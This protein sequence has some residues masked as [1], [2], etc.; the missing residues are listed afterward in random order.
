MYGYFRQRT[1]FSKSNI[2]YIWNMW[3]NW[4]PQW[5]SSVCV[6]VYVQNA[7]MFFMKWNDCTTVKWISSERMK[8]LTELYNG[9]NTDN[10]RPERMKHTKLGCSFVHKPNQDFNWIWMKTFHQWTSFWQCHQVNTCFKVSQVR[11]VIEAN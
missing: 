5:P 4:Q 1:H 2:I 8:M 11:K 7:I 10:R 6:C 9:E 3:T